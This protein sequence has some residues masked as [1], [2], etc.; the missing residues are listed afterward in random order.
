L[1][2][3]RIAYVMEQTLGSVTHY[4]NL[5]RHESASALATPRWLP[6]EF[7]PTRAPWAL[8]G[9]F[10]ARRAISSVLD[11][12]DGLFVH[13]ATIALLA[14]DC[15]GR[16]PAVLSSD[17]TPINKRTMR[18]GYGLPAESALG[19]RAKQAFYRRVFRRAAGF[20]AWSEWTKTSL[21]EDYGCR[22]EDVAVIP[23]GTDLAEYAPGNRDHELPRI[24]FVG[25]DFRRKGGELLL[26]VFRDRL[27]GRAV[28]EL[29]TESE[30][31]PEPGVTVHRGVAPNS[32]K[33]RQLY[34]TCEVFALPTTA[35]CYPVACL[36]ALAAGMPLVTTRI[37]GIP[38]MVREGETGHLIARGDGPALGDALESLLEHPARRRAMGRAA[39]EE[40]SSR[41]EVRTNAR[42]LFEFVRSRC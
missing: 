14:A 29:V 1:S 22:E 4:H 41:F 36:E 33:L 30:V 9:S 10:I 12:V 17:G 15:F 32:E 21:V 3:R 2:A 39:R 37:G 13:T 27:R 5:R 16:K 31:P 8:A 23:P 6:I 35:D 11:Q 40:A 26:Q 19:R 38:D 34:A 20:V 42:R 25:G 7:Q 24:L 18:E 28:L